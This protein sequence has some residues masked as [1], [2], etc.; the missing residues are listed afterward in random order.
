MIAEPLTATEAFVCLDAVRAQVAVFG[1]D[2]TVIWG[3]RSWWR[4][5]GLSPERAGS[6]RLRDFMHG[7]RLA[8]QESL[9]RRV[10][11]HGRS[12]RYTD[13]WRGWAV[14][15]TLRPM[16]EGRVLM[17]INPLVS[18]PDDSGLEDAPLD[19][20]QVSHKALG[21]LDRL[22]KREREVLAL[23]GSG[24]TIKQIAE[25]LER[26]EKTLEGH[27]DSIYR[28]I[29]VKSRAELA[30][31]AIRA[32]LMAPELPEPPA[33]KDGAPPAEAG[34]AKS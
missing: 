26:S 29:G 32:G 28:K 3:N 31:L 13:A 17:M 2:G 4:A 6:V 10:R 5:M 11:Q 15:T 16:D 22:S 18:M 12:V 23:L 1:P 34:E 33:P 7:A 30:I 20:V 24:L 19:R 9:I 21:I 8:E 27:R 14:E 25:R